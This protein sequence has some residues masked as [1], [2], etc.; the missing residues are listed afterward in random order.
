MYIEDF[1]HT[2]PPLIADGWEEESHA[3]KKG[4]A[5]P[6]THAP[7]GALTSEEKKL[8]QE[9][10]AAFVKRDT[11]VFQSLGEEIK[12]KRKEA[13][14]SIK[15]KG[16]A[17]LGTRRNVF[18]RSRKTFRKRLRGGTIEAVEKVIQETPVDGLQIINPESKFVVATYW[19][20]RANMNRNLQY[21]CPE[22]IKEM[23]KREVLVKIGQTQGYPKKFVDIGI[24]LKQLQQ[25]RELTQ[26]EQELFRSVR[27]TW[28]EWVDK[29]LKSEENKDLIQKVTKEV[30]ERELKKPG[31]RPVRGFP[32]MIR[33]WEEKCKAANVNYIALNTEFERADYQN[34]ING[35]PLFI[36]KMLDAVKP[37]AIVYIDG[38]MWFHKYPHI[39]DIDNV[40]FMARGWNMDPRS[41]QKSIDT[42]Y[43]DPYTF[44][45]SG[46]TMYFGNTDRARE[47]LDQ[48]SRESSKPEQKGK[49]DDRILSQIFTTLSLVVNTNIIQLPIEYLWLTDLYASFLKDASSPASIED[50]IIEHPYC[51]TG[52]ERATDQG[53]AANRTPEGY[54]EE[55]VD[56][57]N[58]K[59][60][61]EPFYEYIFFDGNKS[62]RDGFD[63]Y[64]KFMKEAKGG[65]TKEPM[66]N[67]IGFDDKY[68]KYNDIATRNLEGLSTPAAPTGQSVKLPMTATI[69]EILAALYA[70][71]DVELG[72]D[73][74]GEPEDEFVATDASEKPVDMY[75]RHIRVDTTSPM[76]MSAKS[77]ML[78]HLLAMCEKLDD[79]N[80]HVEGS[81]MFMSRIRWNLMK[82]AKRGKKSPI[83]VPLPDEDTEFPAIVHQIWFGAD[84]PEWRK[85]MFDA[86]KAICEAHGYKYRL[87]QNGDRTKENFPS[88][89][90]YQ[91]T[92]IETGK[93]SGQSRW[94]QVADLA[95]LEIIYNHGGIYIDS[96]IEISPA[97]LK[98]IAEAVN[99]GSKFVGCNEDPCEPAVDCV[100][101]EGNK[102]LTNSFFAATK[103]NG[104]LERLL[105]DKML[106]TIDFDSEFINRTTGP[107]YLRSGIENVEADKVFMLDSK[108]IYQFNQQATPYKEVTPN[109]FLFKEQVPGSIKVKD[110][111]YYLPGGIEMLQTNFI[112]EQKGPLATYHSG[113]GGTW[114]T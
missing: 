5:L 66:L 20:G 28:V 105:N 89:I 53:A 15:T 40:D 79:I 70:G 101:Y 81:Y 63:R 86:N 33:E 80:T 31:S 73:I 92:A 95:R 112:V 52:E 75:T 50:A 51:L 94:A 46:G 3:K 107:Y 38:D 77:H 102:Y 58:Y 68:G 22:D 14:E 96:L 1:E 83:P 23:V 56:N 11:P 69:P 8:Q 34:G 85:R 9:R 42:P 54:D 2:I 29:V 55:V 25:K 72:G 76:F 59:R 113:L 97:F 36:K 13:Q 43:Y 108:Q 39:F 84:M 26:G 64:L 35:K 57:I 88:T 24:Q 21:P 7:L 6:P 60:P 93:E 44:E 32:D 82:G 87:W 48:W 47:L 45:T 71:N 99:K 12:N 49:A 10:Y 16:I 18:G 103:F 111:M 62:M 67:I 74:K 17:S 41:K 91:E 110:G 106:A 65:F 109:P 27:K 90:G 78:R 100:G 98:A 19:W 104:V 4:M 114:S 30:E 37:R 61:A